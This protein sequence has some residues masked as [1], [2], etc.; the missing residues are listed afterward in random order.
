MSYLY[1]LDISLF[2]FINNTLSNPY[3]DFLFVSLTDYDKNPI[4]RV[5]ILGLL[6]LCLFRGDDK[7]RLFVVSL[8]IA[9]VVSDQLNSFVFKNIFQRVRPC[10]QLENV[11]SLVPCGSGFSF[12]SSH[13]INN[14]TLASVVAFYFKKLSIPIYIFAFLIAFSRVYVGVH[15]PFDVLVGSILGL[16]IGYT[17]SLH[18]VKIYNNYRVQDE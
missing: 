18:S 4:A 2:Y 3:F 8:I 15:F 7:K 11:F 17:I 10:N 1:N 12:P 13:A 5:L 6:A 14:F 9:I 16:I